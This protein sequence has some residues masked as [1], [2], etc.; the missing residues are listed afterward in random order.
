MAKLPPYMDVMTQLLNAK[1]VESTK[2]V[3]IDETVTMTVGEGESAVTSRTTKKVKKLVHPPVTLTELKEQTVLAWQQHAQRR[4]HKPQ[5]A[6]KVTAVKKKGADPQF[7]Q[8]QQQPQQQAGGSGSGQADQKKKSR[9]GKHSEAGQEKQEKHKKC[10]YANDPAAS[11]TFTS[12]APVVLSPTAPPAY[13]TTFDPRVI[14]HTP[15]STSYG[16]PAFPHTKNAIS[17]THHLGLMPTQETV[18]TLNPV[19]NCHIDWTGGVS[20]NKRPR[21]EECIE[22]LSKPITSPSNHRHTNT[23]GGESSSPR[24]PAKVSNVH[25]WDEDNEYKVDVFGSEK[26]LVDD[27][28]INQD[29]VFDTDQFLGTTEDFGFDME[30]W[31][32]FLNSLSP[33][34]DV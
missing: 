33:D 34:A 8:Q 29:D 21:L 15:G 4:T 2:D 26:D 9:Q 16:E 5:Q 28:C 23:F 3:E 25:T 11:F 13:V 12:S 18:R 6:N 14:S 22:D 19:A 32:V 27:Y 20:T 17:L 1:S 30:E 10:Q 7:Q 31:S 24:D